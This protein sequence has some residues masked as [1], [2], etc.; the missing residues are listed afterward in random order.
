MIILPVGVELFHADRETGGQG[1][2]RTGRQADKLTD[3]TERI[4]VF[5]NFANAPKK[6]TDKMHTYTDRTI[7]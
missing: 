4:F 5:H 7:E 2:R 3:M 1:D 6:E